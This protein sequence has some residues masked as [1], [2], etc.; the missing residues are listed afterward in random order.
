L[1]AVAVLVLAAAAVFFGLLP[2]AVGA[3]MNRVVRRPPFRVAAEAQR[4]HDALFVADLHADTLLWS[5]DLLSRGAWGHVDVPRLLDGRVALQAFTIVTKTPR[6]QNIDRNDADS[7]NITL[8]ALAQRWPPATWKSLTER[9]LYQAARFRDAAERSQGTLTL[10]RSV[11]DFDAYLA[12]RKTTP[13]ITAGFL[14]VEGAQA[15]DG[16]LAN[17]DRLFDAGVRMMAPTHFFDT[18][19]GG[20]AHG[21]ARSGLTPI[22]RDWVALMEDRRILIDL[23]HASAATIDDVLSLATRPVVVS[24]TGLRATCDNARNL[25]DDQLRRIAGTGGVV[26]IGFWDTAVCG[27]SPASIV[28]TIRHAADVA[29][30]DHV[31]L[32]SDYDGAVTAG[33]DASGMTLLT[34]AL[35]RARFSEQD[36]RKVMGEN[37]LR[38]LRESLPER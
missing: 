30:V 2:A 37:V 3:W 12:R 24:H 18:Q 19:I 13:R 35:Q 36:I 5:R 7:D 28:R 14:G 20:S 15:L 21:I 11:R 8:L 4:L 1:T 10:V 34:E 29:G 32:G 31:A 25:T 9:A 33:F 17:L 38:V 26:G 16:N 6:G 22:G 27:T 23:A